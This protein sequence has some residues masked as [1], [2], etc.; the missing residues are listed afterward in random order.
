MNKQYFTSFEQGSQT[1]PRIDLSEFYLMDEGQLV[2]ALLDICQISE[3]QRAEAGE[4]ASKLVRKIRSSSDRTPVI[5]AFLQEYGLSTE[6]G[7]ILMRLAE[8]LIRTP[9]KSNAFS[10]IRDKIE[11]GNWSSH[12]GDSPSRIVDLATLGLGI[13]KGWIKTTGGKRARNLAARIGD[14]ALYS[15]IFRVMQ[16]MGDHYVLGKNIQAAIRKSLK[17][18]GPQDA[19]SFDMLGE[20][21][22]TQADADR[23]FDAY[24]SALLA[25]ADHQGKQ[26]FTP[27]QAGLSVKL[28]ALHPRYEFVQKEKCVP[29]LVGR[30]VELAGLARHHDLNITIDA[31]EAE[32][33]E[34]SLEVLKRLSETTE[35]RDWNGLGFVV[36]AYQRRAIPVIQHLIRLYE[37]KPNIL[38]IRLVKGA[39]WDT[40][41]KRAQEMGLESYPVFTRKE[42]TDVSYLACA[43][44][45]LDAPGSIFPRFATHNAQTAASIIQMAGTRQNYEFQRLHGM[46][47]ELHEELKS[48][49]GV[50][51]RVYA[52]VGEHEDLLPYLVR[53]LLENGANSSFVNQ[54][55]SDDVSISEIIED[56]INKVTTNSRAPHPNIHDPRDHFNGERLAARGIDFTQASVG[57][58]LSRL[59]GKFESVQAHSLIAGKK[60]SQSIGEFQVNC[61]YDTRKIAG[62][63]EATN[64]ASIDA[65][66]SLA[67]TSEWVT[68]FS[69]DQRR[70]VLNKVG[71]LL[72]K[73]YDRLLTLC[74]KEAGKTWPDAIAEVREAI[75]FCFYYANQVEERDPLGVVACISPWNFPLAIFLG[76]IIGA[77]A[78]G[79]SVICKPAAQTPLIA[80][81]AIQLLYQ[82]GV[83]DS[84]VH[85]VLGDGRELGNHLS[86]HPDIHGVC[87]TGSTATAKKIASQLIKTER[88]HIPLI[89]ETGGLNAMI[90]DSTA[91]LEQVVADVIASAFQSAGQRCS[92][93]RVVCIQDD[94]ADAFM[95]MLAGAMQE[96]TLSNPEYLSTDVGPVIDISARTMLENYIAAS[97]TKYRTIHEVPLNENTKNGVFVGPVAFEIPDIKVLEREIFGPV[98]HIVKFN[99]KN[100]ETLIRDINSLGYGLTMG[101]HTRIDDRVDQISCL[102][103]VGNLYVNRNQI[104]AVVGVQ[105][106]GGEGL[107]GTG[108]KAGGPHYVRRLSKSKST[109]SED[110]FHSNEKLSYE[111]L[112]EPLDLNAIEAASTAWLGQL[113]KDKI[114]KLVEIC[115]GH[116]GVI[117]TAFLSKIK[118]SEGRQIT[119]PG[120]TGESNSLELNPR[121]IILCDD[122]VLPEVLCQQLLI[123]LA[124]GNA[125]ILLS[126]DHEHRSSLEKLITKLAAT[127]GQKNLIQLVD[128]IPFSPENILQLGAVLT[129]QERIN[130]WA[131]WALSM[132]GQLVPILTSDDEIERF[133]IERTL[134]V[135]TTAAGG[136][137]TLLAM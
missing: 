101:L 57:A 36:Q 27:G 75:D 133:F 79:N 81:E 39:Y 93:C 72:G 20:A 64:V 44:T 59:I 111:N 58:R 107:S 61:P 37:Q 32:R 96:L 88:A 66:V 106:F 55:T 18:A 12:R 134:T 132:N 68:Q 54:L 125:V 87:F 65:A 76:Q 69:P 103:R 31:E 86:A 26:G 80:Y 118:Y 15:A 136:N 100:L 130:I 94:V 49:S 34:V 71:Y 83:P 45:L 46:G 70:N 4:L 77:L 99:E 104:G 91:L 28:S 127:T 98:L 73:N 82:A 74:V 14:R 13:T 63:W 11:P 9:D 16:M 115:E 6:E 78:G 17:N 50:S 116:F 114:Q 102:A 131:E 92:A 25:I 97:K 62:Y 90:V 38:N 41:I 52:P 137:A 56:P 113:N 53:R 122:R 121:G 129:C 22:Y 1:D 35:L 40:E 124:T 47:K 43:K 117:D 60:P 33:L 19:Y 24:R 110:V 120:P 5:D 135:N 8:S 95:T 21:A 123:S 7:I 128:G 126:P 85:L 119:L 112:V 10:L 108:P 29:E 42:N 105:P 2:S 67:R 30:L 3:E 84:A 51:S 23:Y 89:A 48:V 109:S